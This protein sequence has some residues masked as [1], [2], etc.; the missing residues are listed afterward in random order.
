MAG[1]AINN[2]IKYVLRNG[3]SKHTIYINEANKIYNWMRIVVVLNDLS[4]QV[5][6]S[7]QIE[8]KENKC[9]EY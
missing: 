7:W 6:G 2:G 5:G 9:N 1:R 8:H 3:H 4:L